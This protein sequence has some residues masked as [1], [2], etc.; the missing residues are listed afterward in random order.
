MTETGAYG[1][2]I[3]ELAGNA[4]HPYHTFAISLRIP[5]TLNSTYAK[6]LLINELERDPPYN[7]SIDVFFTS[8]GD[9]WNLPDWTSFF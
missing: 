4:I 2:P 6:D 3:P 5:P 9:G 7:A 1:L 8:A